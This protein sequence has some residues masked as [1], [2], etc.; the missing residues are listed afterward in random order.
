MTSN[1]DHGGSVVVSFYRYISLGDARASEFV[2]EQRRLG[3]E[4]RLL[5]RILVAAEGVSGT[6]QGSVSAIATYEAAV[7]ASLGVAL[8]WKHSNVGMEPLFPDL[9]V[10]EVAELVS[11]GDQLQ[12]RKDW[13]TLDVEAEGGTH[14]DPIEFDRLLMETPP[15]DLR[16]IDVRNSFEYQI[17]HFDGAVDPGMT[18]TAQWPRFVEKNLEDLRGKQVLLYCTGGIRCEKASAFLNRR[19]HETKPIASMT[20]VP[21]GG[22]ERA[23]SAVQENDKAAPARGGVFQ[24]LGGIHRYLEAFPEGSRFRGANFVFDKREKQESSNAA[25]IV[26][27][28]SECARPWGRHHGGRVCCVCRSLVLVC[29]ACD[30]ATEHGEYYC[31]D[32]EELRGMYFHFVDSFS[33]SELQRQA[34]ELRKKLAAEV[35]QRRKNRRATL[36]KKA[37]QIEARIA[38]LREAEATG[39]VSSEQQLLP[40]RCRACERPYT[41]CPGACW[42]FWLDR[43]RQERLASGK[44]GENDGS[45]AGQLAETMAIGGGA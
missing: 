19:L 6:V 43:Q 3:V 31:A 8:D 26:G 11:F 40:R 35:G 32:H 15:E 42:G 5:G 39:T 45:C 34:C 27:A 20:E 44:V 30:D 7:D 17:G 13:P 2:T 23:G 9:A 37:E 16:V 10:K 41:D 12:A 36:R 4:L 24:L 14:L 33:L 1:R 22:D 28:C 38:V 25:D 21:T 29:D 18:H